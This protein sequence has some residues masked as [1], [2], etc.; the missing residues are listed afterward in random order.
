MTRLEQIALKATKKQD[1]E[2]KKAKAKGED[3]ETTASKKKKKGKRKVKK[4][5]EAEEKAE[6][7]EEKAEV[8]EK[9]AE[10]GEKKRKKGTGT[11]QAKPES[12]SPS[13][14]KRRILRSANKNG[15]GD[16]IEAKGTASDRPAPPSKRKSVKSPPS[17]AAED[18]KDEPSEERD[19]F[20][21]LHLPK[22]SFGVFQIRCQGFQIVYRSV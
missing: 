21:E 16:G 5:E 15:G 14:R 18:A 10:E 2:K 22:T 20:F 4:A 3:A 11:K 13:K 19:C 7:A 6:A 1:R 17:P 12:K 8:A 9:K